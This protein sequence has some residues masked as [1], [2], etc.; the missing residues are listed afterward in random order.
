MY[1]APPGRA[2][3]AWDLLT[4]SKV[5][6]PQTDELPSLPNQRV[7]L[8]R[9]L[10]PKTWL[11]DCH[12]QLGWAQHNVLH[13]GVPQIVAFSMQLKLL[14]QPGFPFPLLGLVHIANRI[15]QY[16]PLRADQPLSV[17]V[18]FTGVERT[19]KGWECTVCTDVYQMGTLVWQSLASQ[20][21]R[22][23]QERSNS[24]SNKKF[25]SLDLSVTECISR[26]SLPDHLGRQYARLSGDFNPIHLYSFTAKFFGFAGH[27]AHGMWTKSR[28]LSE[29][30]TS[31]T[32]SFEVS[33]DFKRPVFLPAEV[34]LLRCGSDFYLCSHNRQQLH[35]RGN[36]TW[37]HRV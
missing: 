34:E 6:L 26:L 28:C 36:I 29:L 22:K 32:H 37:L 14:L 13:P 35:I 8:N 4:R 18:Y 20:L 19:A 17:E 3:I 21:S 5:K 2:E 33:T 25:Q 10:I 9:Y 30:I 7:V 15:V 11:T 12:R 31:D 1:S 27:I 16:R 24:S 23:P